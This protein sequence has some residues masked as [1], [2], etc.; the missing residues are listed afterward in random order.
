MK[1]LAAILTLTAAPALAHQGAHVH[2]HAADAWIGVALGLALIAVA[3][4]GARDLARVR[5]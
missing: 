3:L 2:P 5:S 1:Y 4:S